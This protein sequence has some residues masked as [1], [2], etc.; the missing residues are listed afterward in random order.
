MYEGER[1]AGYRPD[2]FDA[3]TRHGERYQRGGERYGRYRHGYRY[4]YTPEYGRR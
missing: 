4:R 3:I 2:R 1:V